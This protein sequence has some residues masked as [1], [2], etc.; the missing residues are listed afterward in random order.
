MSQMKSLLC[1]DQNGYFVTVDTW[2]QIVDVVP[3]LL[4]SHE[5]DQTMFPP[6]V[7]KNSYFATTAIMDGIMSYLVTQHI[8]VRVRNAA[9]K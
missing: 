6:G 1:A 5:I 2:Y 4:S 8:I 9:I 3:T 7:R